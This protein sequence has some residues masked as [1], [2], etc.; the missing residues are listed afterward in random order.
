MPRRKRTI[1]EKRS[2]AGRLGGITTVLRYGPEHYRE[3]QAKR[4]VFRG[5]KPKATLGEIKAQLSAVP[6]Y[7]GGS[8][9]DDLREL[10]RLCKLKY[11]RRG[12]GLSAAAAPRRR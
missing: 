8:L 11:G 6:K 9:P 4:T 3:I 1:S 2:D 5:R 12:A 7:E 10:K